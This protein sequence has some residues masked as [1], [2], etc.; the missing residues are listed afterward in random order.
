M[1]GEIIDRP[2]PQPLPSHI[3]DHVTDLAIKLQNVKLSDGDLQGLDEFRRAS[4]YIAAG[5]DILLPNKCPLSTLPFSP[6]A[7]A[8]SHN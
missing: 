7:I 2:N 1:P 3:P 4:N 5:K 8:Q 6:S